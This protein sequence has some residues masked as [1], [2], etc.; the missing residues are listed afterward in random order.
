MVLYSKCHHTVKGCGSGERE[1][2]RE[3]HMFTMFLADVHLSYVK[4]LVLKTVTSYNS[5][6]LYLK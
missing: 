4:K 3:R 5:H 2:E 6:M 1:R